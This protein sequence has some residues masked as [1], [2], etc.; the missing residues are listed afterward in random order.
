[1]T[2]TQSSPPLLQMNNIEKKFPGVVALND[3]TFQVNGGEIHALL[4]Q[5]A[6]VN[7]P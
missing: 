1:M 2:Q 6:L 3:V 7:L 5:M 4:V